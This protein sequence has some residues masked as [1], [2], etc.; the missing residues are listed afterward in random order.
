[1]YM[2]QLQI[3]RKVVKQEEEEETKK[4]TLQN[5]RFA[6]VLSLSSFFSSSSSSVFFFLFSLAHTKAY[7]HIAYESAHCGRGCV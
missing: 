2:Y 7:V 1:M 3:Q 6:C 5:V 4:E